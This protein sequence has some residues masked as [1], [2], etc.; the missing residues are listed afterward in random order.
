MIDVCLAII[1]L[2]DSVCRIGDSYVWDVERD[3]P[4]LI[5]V[6]IIE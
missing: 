2:S 4:A 6:E 3:E 1:D 5:L